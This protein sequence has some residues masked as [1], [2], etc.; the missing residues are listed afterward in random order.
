MKTILVVEDSHLT[1][2]LLRRAL[3]GNNTYSVEHFCKNAENLMEVYEQHRPD[4]VVMDIVM[5]GANGI[6]M[7]RQ[8]V[9]AH[10][11]AR[12]V[13]L[14][15][16]SYHEVKDMANAAGAVGYIQ[17]PFRPQQVIDAFDRALAK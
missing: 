1:Y 13:V 9:A 10:S 11:E 4:L 16:L 7:T 8:L 15:S 14:S 17:K 6:D 3:A 12:V 2:E 5:E